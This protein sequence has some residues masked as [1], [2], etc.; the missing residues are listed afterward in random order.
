[1]KKNNIIIVF[2]VLVVMFGLYGFAQ[3]V[4][5]DQEAERARLAEAVAVEQKEITDVEAERA[6]LAESDALLWRIQA[7]SLR[8]KLIKKCK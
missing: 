1:M 6:K 3:K 2:A 7:D 8:A 5:A 4:K